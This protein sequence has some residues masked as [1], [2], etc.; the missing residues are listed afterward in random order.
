M[1]EQN[2][3]RGEPAT[4]L[5]REVHCNFEGSSALIESLTEG[6]E[7]ARRHGLSE[8]AKVHNAG[9]F[10][11]LL[12]RD[13]VILRYDLATESDRVRKVF[14]ARQ[15][16]IVVY[17]GATDLPA[18]FGKDY[19]LA[20]T[21]IG[22]EANFIKNL[23]TAMRPI[24]QFMQKNRSGLEAIRNYIAAHRDHNGW[25]QAKLMRA[26]DPEKLLW[27][28][29]AFGRLL[30]PLVTFQ[31]KVTPE[32]HRL[33]VARLKAAKG[34]DAPNAFFGVDSVDCGRQFEL[35]P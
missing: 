31:G 15:L 26:I 6:Y 22:M 23:G 25:L 24:S 10:L 19:R 8:M 9:I 17:E 21:A 11:L 16:A 27:V 29:I 5:S 32:V 33:T 4:V 2:I 13:V 34:V 14:L 18:V 28:G 7:E 35:D 12:Q 3:Q 1:S 30:V 20:L